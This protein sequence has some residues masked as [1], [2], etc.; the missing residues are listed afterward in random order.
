M[1]VIQIRT[2][3][4]PMIET[5]LVYRWKYEFAKEIFANVIES[6]LTAEPPSYQT[7][8]DLDRKVREKTLPAH[9]N[10]FMSP[11]DVN[12][13]PSAYMRGCVLHTYRTVSKY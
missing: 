13:T 2:W 3:P 7:I 6:T 1:W 10:V 12:C 9:L 8:L 11:D 4:P 5:S